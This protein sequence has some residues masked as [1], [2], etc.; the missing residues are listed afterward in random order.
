MSVKMVMFSSLILQL[1]LKDK[2]KYVLMARGIQCVLMDLAIERL[3]FCVASKGIMA[4][5]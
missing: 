1:L 3:A 2:Y 5:S 4:V